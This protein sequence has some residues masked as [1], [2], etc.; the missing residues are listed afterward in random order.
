MDPKIV[1]YRACVDEFEAHHLY[2]SLANTPMLNQRF[3]EV[4]KRA[5]DDEFNHY[6][7]WKEVVG[8]CRSSLS[9]AKVALYK[10]LLLIFGITIVLKIIESMEVN[11]SKLYRDI[12]NIEPGLRDRIA[13]IIE[14]EERHEREF[15]S[16]I[17]E[18]R[19]RYLGSITLGI[20]DALIELTGIYTG[21]LGAFEN[22]L[23]AGLTGLL[24]G[25]A[26]SI[27]MGVASYSQAKHEAIKNPRISALYTSIAYIVVVVLL[28][29]PYFILNSI[30]IA[31]I[32]MIALAMAVV[33]YMT[34]Y[35]AILHNK[36]FLREFIESAALILGVSLLLY[37]LGSILGRVIGIKMG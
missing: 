21:S 9:M 33:A 30:T 3:K 25:I 34:F 36:N 29:L 23:S 22:T 2:R 11:A 8:D 14:D 4:L 37:I 6:S 13:R 24:A 12:A 17:D 1:F 5:A 28:A 10:L 19:V 18:G 31:F 20:S 15:I 26:A 16:S 35:T 7:F 32:V 27:S